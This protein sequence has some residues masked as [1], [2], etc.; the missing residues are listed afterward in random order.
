MKKVAAAIFAVIVLGAQV[1]W[2]A[3]D[4]PYVKLTQVGAASRFFTYITDA[5]DGSGRLFAVERS[6]RIWVIQNNEFADSPFLDISNQV[7]M[8]GEGG[9]LSLVFPTGAG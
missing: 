4:W 1:V 3:T 7:T 2:S 8:S 9:L 6:G 5:G